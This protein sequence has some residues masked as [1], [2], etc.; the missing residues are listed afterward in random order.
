M[1]SQTDAYELVF[2]YPESDPFIGPCHLKHGEFSR[3]LL[4]F[5]IAMVPTYGPSTFIDVGA[6]LGTICLPFAK[7]QPEWRTLAIEAHGGLASLLHTNVMINKLGN[8]DVLHAAAGPT[9]EIIDFPATPLTLNMNFGGIHIGDM[10][11]P[12]AATVMLSLD[13]IAPSNTALVKIDVEA[14]EPQVLRG[15]QRLVGE[16][17]ITWIVE[18]AVKSPETSLETVSIFLDAGYDVYWFYVP[19]VTPNSPKKGGMNVTVG[20]ANIVALPKGSPNIWKL[21]KLQALTDPRPGGVRDYPYLAY[22]G[23][24]KPPPPSQGTP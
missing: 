2:F 14:F 13:E 11:S 3:S 19:F 12:K 7:S 15:A 4:D 23:Y 24:F 9:R 21:P 20:D 16:Q 10:L 1:L 17:K 22:Y 6:N 5:L 18:A 8:V